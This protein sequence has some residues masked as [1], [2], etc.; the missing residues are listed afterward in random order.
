MSLRPYLVHHCFSQHLGEPRPE[1]CRCVYRVS[2][3][4]RDM[5]I[6]EGLAEKLVENIPTDRIREYTCPLCGNDKKFVRSCLNCDKKGRLFEKIVVQNIS[7]NVVVTVSSP[8]EAGEILG[9]V[10]DSRALKTPR[11]AT[12]ERPQIE[13][14]YLPLEKVCGQWGYKKQRPMDVDR[15]E[16]WGVLAQQVIDA[17]T[18]AYWPELTDHFKGRAVLM[19]VG[20]QRTMGR[21]EREGRDEELKNHSN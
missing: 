14:A 21:I 2:K 16:E 17:M 11:V 3:E 5:L 8:A 4:D 6:A 10:R 9:T 1:H 20:D 12:L 18:T 19:M 13:R 15:I 7:E